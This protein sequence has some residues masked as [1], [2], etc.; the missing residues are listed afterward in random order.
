MRQFPHLFSVCPLLA[1][2][3]IALISQPMTA[4]A[5]SDTA[6]KKPVSKSTKLKLDSKKSVASKVKS[7][8]KIAFTEDAD[9]ESRERKKKNGKS[10]G[11]DDDAKHVGIPGRFKVNAANKFKY[12]G[13]EDGKGEYKEIREWLIRRKAYPAKEVDWKADSNARERAMS[14]PKATPEMIRGGAASQTQ[15]QGVKSLGAV[16]PNPVGLAWQFIGPTNIDPPYRQYYGTQPTIGRI[17]ALAFDAKRPNI[18]YLGGASGGVWKSTTSGATWNSIMDNESGLAVSSIAVDP[19]NSAVVYVGTGD[20]DGFGAAG[21]GFFKSVDGGVNWTNLDPSHTIFNRYAIHKILID[22]SSLDPTTGQSKSILATGGWYSPGGRIFSSNNSGGAWTTTLAT[23]R[24]VNDIVFN[25]DRTVAYAATD[26]GGLYKSTDKGA[27]WTRVSTIFQTNTGDR[28]DVAA[29]LV[30][31][32]TLYVLDAE[33]RSL[34]T[35]KDGAVTWK[36]NNL[37]NSP[38][39]TGQWGQSFYDFYL[40][41][42]TKTVRNSSGV[43]SVTSDVLFAGLFSVYHS[44]DAGKTWFDA[45]Q[46]YHSGTLAHSD[47][48]CFAISPS[49]PNSL[50]VGGDGGAYRFIF[51][52]STSPPGAYTFTSINI[53]LGITQFYNGSVSPIDPTLLI[54]GTQD[55]ATPQANGDTQHWRNP[56]AGDGFGCAIN[57]S[58]PFNPTA[59]L[60]GYQNQYLTIYGN[61][62]IVTEDNW[63]TAEDITPAVA[64]GVFFTPFWLNSGDSLFAYTAD[65]KLYE[66]QHPVLGVAN[67]STTW[68]TFGQDFVNNVTGFGSSFVKVRN[69]A[70]ASE[71]ILYAGTDSGA[72]WASYDHGGTFVQFDNQGSANGLPNLPITSVT[73]SPVNPNKIWVTM[74]GGGS[75]GHIWTSDNVAG[76]QWRSVSGNLPDLPVNTLALIPGDLQTM[77]VGTDAGVYFTKDGGQSW[78]DAS[79]PLGMPHVMV[80]QLA[81]AP[82]TG[83]LNAFTYGRGMWRLLIGNTNTAFRIFPDLQGFRGDKTKLSVEVDLFYPGTSVLQEIRQAF[84]TQGG[85]AN[86]LLSLSGNADILIKIPGFLNKRINGISTTSGLIRPSQFLAGDVNRDNA[87]TAA[88]LGLATAKLGRFTKGPEDVDGDG[89]VTVND[90]NLINLNLGKRGDQ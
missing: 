20:Y 88:D 1:G 77:Y 89:K 27:S 47:Q 11:K 9:K 38:A 69:A 6:A 55:N 73:V 54:G 75:G 26:Y 42:T 53:G 84:L 59:T 49:N 40:G 15:T 57:P 28:I 4:A 80:T 5:Q 29:S 71:Y 62:V 33:N 56:G 18:I 78:F 90:I 58:D 41:A 21:F 25:S 50:L 87:V 2:L 30:S 79:I 12:I 13:K 32:G 16:I 61:R 39:F 36:T 45:S 65:N 24:P 82:S 81:Y 68:T 34:Y 19:N 67:T 31:P 43:G 70:G 48:H 60:R 44:P 35:S 10:A 74:S 7:E 86:I 46:S 17:G 37:D 76:G 72:L 83:Y 23:S 3:S 8:T 14:M 64:T 63:N 52:P 22:P 51:A 66:Y 85:Y